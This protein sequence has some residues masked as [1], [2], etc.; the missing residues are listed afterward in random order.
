MH[1]AAAAVT[2]LSIVVSPSGGDT[3]KHWTLRCGPPGG[4]LPHAAEA[5]T[6]L[7]RL[8]TPF[9][10]TPPGTACS[11]IYGGPQTARVSGIYRGRR[12]LATFTRR[13]GCET[14]RWRRVAF[15]FPGSLSQ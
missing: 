9:K 6:K 13:D 7:Y 8:D 12:I 3:M 10:P 2:V 4:T 5:C 1:A 14:A 11:Q 15:L